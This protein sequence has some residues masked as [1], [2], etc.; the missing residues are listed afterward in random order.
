MRYECYDKNGNYLG[1]TLS[2]IEA[3]E[4][5]KRKSKAV[6]KETVVVTDTTN[7]AADNETVDEAPHVP[8]IDELK[9]SEADYSDV[10]MEIFIRS[11][12][13]AV[14]TS[15]NFVKKC[16]SLKRSTMPSGAKRK[17]L[18]KETMNL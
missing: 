11:A 5:K 8:T 15:R 7:E 18:F 13:K 3:N 2:K 16:A 6:A 17:E 10:V 9:A 1:N 14:R 12:I 4:K